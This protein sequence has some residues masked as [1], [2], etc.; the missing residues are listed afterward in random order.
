[1]GHNGVPKYNFGN[2][3]KEEG[4]S[5]GQ[6]L[7]VLMAGIIGWFMKSYLS[8]KGKNLALREDIAKI[9]NDIENVK[10]YYAVLLQRRSRIHERQIE[11][12]GKLYKYLFEV[13]GYAQRM[14]S[15]VIFEGEKTEEYPALF[16]SAL[17]K[18]QKEFLSGCLLLPIDIEEQVNSFFQKVLEGQLE[19]DIAHHPMVPDGQVRAG[20]W[21]KAGAIAHLEMPDLLE[22]I[23]KQARLIIYPEQEHDQV[24]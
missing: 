18:A 22:T 4:M 23:K 15:A 14:T 20:Y 21:K 3:R 5:L 12:L 16:S 10:L 11:I 8:E 1:L 24:P 17:K 2:E 19:L 9:T 6:L 7:T 13:Q